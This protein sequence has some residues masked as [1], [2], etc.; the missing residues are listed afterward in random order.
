MA[1]QSIL[2]PQRS[3]IATLA[4][5]YWANPVLFATQPE[6]ARIAST[7]AAFA[8]AGRAQAA[9]RLKQALRCLVAQAERQLGPRDDRVERGQGE[10]P[11]E[12][13]VHSELE[14]DQCIFG[15]QFDGSVICQEVAEHRLRSLL[16]SHLVFLDQLCNLTEAQTTKLRLAGEATIRRFFDRVT[17]TRLAFSAIKDNQSAINQLRDELHALRESWVMEPFLADSLFAKVLAK[18][19]SGSQLAIYENEIKEMK[20]VEHRELIESFIQ[21]ERRHLSLSVSQQQQL[22][23]LLLR[24]TRHS[25]RL[26]PYRYVNL[27]AQVSRIPES[28][29]QPIFNSSQWEMLNHEFK[30][31]KLAGPNALDSSWILSHGLH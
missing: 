28:R 21:L 5:G 13:G 18:T 30:L 12:N 22:Q 25:R 2:T 23:E 16:E 8:R 10:A 24:E 1:A 31:A 7:K 14:F 3:I 4:I 9:L 20:L 26:R 15:Q 11:L 6:L 17:G 27:M 19:L 29:I